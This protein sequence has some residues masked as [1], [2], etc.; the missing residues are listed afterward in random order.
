MWNGVDC[1]RKDFVRVRNLKY[2]KQTEIIK[3][4]SFSLTM[5]GYI[6]TNFHLKKDE[7]TVPALLSEEA[8]VPHKVNSCLAAEELWKPTVIYNTV[9][10]HVIVILSKFSALI[11][12]YIFKV[13]NLLEKEEPGCRVVC[14]KF[15]I[16]VCVCACVRTIGTAPESITE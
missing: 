5:Q 16:C 9:T 10:F 7:S 8:R 14:T 13:S 6:H 15:Q 2:Y 12:S 4:N 11:S 1:F 3:D